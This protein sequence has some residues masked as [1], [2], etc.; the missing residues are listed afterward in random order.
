DDALGEGARVGF[1]PYRRSRGGIAA[2]LLRDGCRWRRG[3][4]S[5]AL[6]RDH[7]R[8]DAT[9]TDLVGPPAWARARA[10]PEP[11]HRRARPL[12][13]RR[14]PAGRPTAVAAH[15]TAARPPAA[16]PTAAGLSSSSQPPHRAA[17]VH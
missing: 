14:P 12:T 15:L 6:R 7:A 8:Q 13:V 3:G 16:R 11:V 2:N 10:H 9:A 1:G 4:A 17:T 5:L